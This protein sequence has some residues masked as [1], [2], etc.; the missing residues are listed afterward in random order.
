[1]QNTAGKE[2]V[3]K[4]VVDSDYLFANFLRAPCFS[5]NGQANLNRW[6]R[7]HSRRLISLLFWRTFTN[8]LRLAERSLLPTGQKTTKRTKPISHE[9]CSK[10]FSPRLSVASRILRTLGP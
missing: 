5:F 9:L 3:R 7:T 2:P 8:R 10:I 6:V 1:M 4:E